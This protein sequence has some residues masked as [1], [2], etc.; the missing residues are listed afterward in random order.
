MKNLLKIFTVFLILVSTS[1]TQEGLIDSPIE[2]KK[3]SKSTVDVFNVV[4]G[5]MVGTSTL[6][7]NK[8]G[9]TV[10]FKTTDLT[11]G[12]AYTLWWVIW[13]NPQEC[14]GYPGACAESDFAIADLVEVEVLYAAGHVVGGS[15]TGKFSGHLN[16]NDASESIN[17][18]FPID[19][20]GGLHDAETAEVHLV[21]RSHGPA[22]PGMV[23]EQIGSYLGGCST[24]FDA[25]TEIPDDVGECGDFEAAIHQL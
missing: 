11:P 7:R 10:N 20:N 8:N 12:Y 21:L 24:F 25:F 16:E 23:N 17:Y 19:S 3:A 5:T 9:I 6:H 18:L 4:N 13:N 1:C 15:G 2:S 14:E 22:I